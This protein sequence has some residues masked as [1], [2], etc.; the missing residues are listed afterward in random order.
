MDGTKVG[1]A[2]ANAASIVEGGERCIG[3]G[4]LTPKVDYQ[5]Q[6]R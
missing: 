2:A 6:G 1:Q 5:P 3:V 4:N